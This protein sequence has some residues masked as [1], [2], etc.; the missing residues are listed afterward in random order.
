MS[1]D[2]IVELIGRCACQVLADLE[3]R[4]LV[5]HRS[6]GELGANS[7]DRAEILMLVLEELHLRIPRVALFGPENIG[8]LADLLHEKLHVN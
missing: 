3:P 2:E 1:R 4:M 7:V 5:A 8:E 6:L